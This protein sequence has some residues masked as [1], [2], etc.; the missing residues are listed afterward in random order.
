MEKHSGPHA[1]WF[2]DTKLS[3]GGVAL[4]MGCHAVE[5]F[6]W[7]LSGPDF[8]SRPAR[9]SVMQMGTHMH[10]DKMCARTTSR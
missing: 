3:G 9:R 5:F 10:G 1:A 4:D 2:Y 7:L 8:A 6:R